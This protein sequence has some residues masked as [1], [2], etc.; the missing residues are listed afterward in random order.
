MCVS[1]VLGVEQRF[2]E[3]TCA[4]EKALRQKLQRLRVG[5]SLR[6]SFRRFDRNHSARQ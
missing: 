4:L 2:E 3:K 6:R 5:P 1:G